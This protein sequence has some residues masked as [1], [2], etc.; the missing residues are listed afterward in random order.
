MLLLGYAMLAAAALLWGAK[1]FRYRGFPLADDV[2]HFS[3]GLCESSQWLAIMAVFFALAI[4]AN[5]T[6][7]N[8]S[9]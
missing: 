1:T 3:Y 4:V 6:S 5:R 7:Q 8:T 9:N 2:C